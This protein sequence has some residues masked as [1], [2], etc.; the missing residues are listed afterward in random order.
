MYHCT[1]SW[2]QLNKVVAVKASRQKNIVKC[3]KKIFLK[4]PLRVGPVSLAP[5]ERILLAEASTKLHKAIKPEFLGAIIYK[6]DDVWLV[7]IIDI[8]YYHLISINTCY[9]DSITFSTNS[10]IKPKKNI[11]QLSKKNLFLHTKKIWSNPLTITE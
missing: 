7:I 5:K 3:V 1:F 6:T 11:I 10:F 4:E 2:P 9:I 8:S